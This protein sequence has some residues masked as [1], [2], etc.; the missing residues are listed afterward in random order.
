MMNSI[1]SQKNADVF[2]ALAGSGFRDF[3]RIAASDPEM[4]HDIFLANRTQ[5][6]AQ[7]DAFKQTLQG[8]ETSLLASDGFKLEAAIAAASKRRVQ[9]RLTQNSK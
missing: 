4:W 1:A 8:F 3:T 6:L 5:L 9:W 7:I 2:L